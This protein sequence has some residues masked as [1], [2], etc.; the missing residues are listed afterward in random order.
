M[1]SSRVEVPAL[2]LWEAAKDLPQS[3]MSM[4]GEICE[5]MW[6]PVFEMVGDCEGCKVWILRSDAHINSHTYKKD[7]GKRRFA[8]EAEFDGHMEQKLIVG[9]KP[10]KDLFDEMEAYLSWVPPGAVKPIGVFFSGH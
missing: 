3:M 10:S 8:L 1:P 4:Q 5:P 7:E 6:A 2:P 9:S